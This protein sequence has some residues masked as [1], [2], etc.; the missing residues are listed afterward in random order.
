MQIVFVILFAAMLGRVGEAQTAIPGSSGGQDSPRRASSAVT[1]GKT[2]A[3]DKVSPTGIPSRAAQVSCRE[4]SSSASAGKLVCSVQIAATDL[5]LYSQ[6]GSAAPI[7]TLMPEDSHIFGNLSAVSYRV[8]NGALEFDVDFERSKDVDV[9]YSVVVV[10]HLFGGEERRFQAQGRITKVS[11]QVT[12]NSTSAVPGSDP[13]AEC[14][15]A[16]TGVRRYVC[17]WRCKASESIW[18][19]VV[20]I[21]VALALAGFALFYF[22]PRATAQSEYQDPYGRTRGSER[23]EGQWEGGKPEVASSGVVPRSPQTVV[24]PTQDGSFD[25]ATVQLRQS[26]ETAQ[27]VQPAVALS[28]RVARL[29]EAQRIEQTR[30]VG[31]LDE[32]RSLLRQLVGEDADIREVGMIFRPRVAGTN[33]LAGQRTHGR[34]EQVLLAVANHW[35]ASDGEDRRSLVQMAGELGLAVRLMQH[36]HLTEIF[37][38]VAAYKDADF[39]PSETDGG[40]LW[41][42]TSATEAL[43]VPADCR[44]F[45][46]GRAPM[47]LDRTFEGAQD[48]AADFKFVT[49]FRVCRLRSK[50]DASRYELVSKGLVQV[51]GRPAPASTPV[52]Y[53]SLLQQYRQR[54]ATEG[55]PTS[56]ARIVKSQL[57]LINQRLIAAERAIQS[58]ANPPSGVSADNE[59]RSALSGVQQRLKALEEKTKQPPRPA[60]A[61][62]AGLPTAAAAPIGKRVTGLEE[63]F[64]T[65]ARRVETVEASLDNLRTPD[66]GVVATAQASEVLSAEPMSVQPPTDLTPLLAPAEPG[67]AVPPPERK[68]AVPTDEPTLPAFPAV[69][70]SLGLPMEPLSMDNLVARPE[71]IPSSPKALPDGWTAALERSSLDGQAGEPHYRRR[72]LTLRDGLVALGGTTAIRVVHVVESQGRLRLHEVASVAGDELACMVCGRASSFQMAVCAGEPGASLVQ[73][74]FPAGGYAPYNYPAG[75][76]QLMQDVPA[77]SFEIRSALSPAILHRAPGGAADE[78]TVAQKMQWS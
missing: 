54:V 57:E 9:D 4:V 12:T 52:D 67:L 34:E 73:I 71:P 28:D 39:E 70:K 2:R 43:A 50:G 60:V 76:A 75:Y 6:E 13:Q 29:E 16:E 40:W 5:A 42:D 59:V 53:I 41:F 1:K 33:V 77:R 21:F 24:G 26:R 65:L 72:L 3:S 35:I 47:L 19:D 61:P 36:V 37:R 66:R 51:T 48:L 74:I 32:V 25:P 64:L 58:Q 31:K 10:V 11:N 69:P 46:G 62:E 30:L 49:F 68:S 20:P 27:F 38:D 56:I 55:G 17:L 78:Y 22:W 18:W 45:R 23:F 14:A 15:C 8:R 44:L 63:D 7:I